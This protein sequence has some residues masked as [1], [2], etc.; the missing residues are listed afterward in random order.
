MTY[1]QTSTV[2]RLPSTCFYVHWPLAIGSLSLCTGRRALV[3]EQ[4]QIDRTTSKLPT[5]LTGQPMYT[6]SHRRTDWRVY[7]SFHHATER[8]CTDTSLAGQARPAAIVRITI[9]VAS[10]SRIGDNERW[11]PCLYGSQNS[12][13]RHRWR[14]ARGQAR[15]AISI[16]G[17]RQRQHPTPTEA[18]KMSLR[19]EV[20]TS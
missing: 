7:R 15:R 18:T 3:T 17:N 8:N 16:S 10:G 4:Q 5:P 20:R 19:R 14:S 1:L 2:Q 9:S 6:Q 11:P 12:S 13:E